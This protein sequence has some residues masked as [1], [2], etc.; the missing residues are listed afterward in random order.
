MKNL[1][2]LRTKTLYNDLTRFR[3]ELTWVI[4]AQQWG[5]PDLTLPQ[6]KA[7]VIKV[8]SHIETELA[9]RQTQTYKA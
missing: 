8:M 9:R 3:R 4:L 6:H 5:S 2:R 1:K 7:D